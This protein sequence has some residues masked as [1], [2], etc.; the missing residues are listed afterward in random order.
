MRINVPW[1]KAAIASALNPD[2]PGDLVIIGLLCSIHSD[3]PQN[4]PAEQ[5][6]Q[7]LAEAA[8]ALIKGYLRLDP[9]SQAWLLT[10]IPS[11]EALQA[12]V[13]MAQKSKNKH[14]QISYLLYHVENANDP[15]IDAALGSEH[16]DVRI[17]AQ[18]LKNIMHKITENKQ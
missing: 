14:I 6:Q 12:I 16:E 18:L 4:I 15:M 3:L 10:I 2:L 9:T 8:D 11:V 5:R 7:L 13:S 17:I 1:I